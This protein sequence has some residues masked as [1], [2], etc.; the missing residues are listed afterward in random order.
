LTTSRRTIEDQLGRP[1]RFFAY[2][3]GGPNH[4]RPEFL[5]MIEQAGYQG[6]LSAYGG[7]VRPGCD[8]R[9]LPR[10]AMPYFKSLSHLELHLSGCLH[11]WYS[12]RGRELG[13]SEVPQGFEDRPSEMRSLPL[14]RFLSSNG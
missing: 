8:A 11:W 14:A 3:F 6:G 7:F 2:P 13:Q 10:E 9:M 1:C 4:F 12:L 5:P